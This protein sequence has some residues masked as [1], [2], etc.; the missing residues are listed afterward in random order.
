MPELNEN[1]LPNDY[2]VYPGYLYVCDGEV[3]RCNIEGTVSD[4]KFYTGSKEIKNCDI[5]GRLEES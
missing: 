4:L 3:V 5:F 2:S 1:V